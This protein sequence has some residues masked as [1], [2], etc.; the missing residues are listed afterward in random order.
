MADLVLL[1]THEAELRRVLSTPDGSEAAAYLLLG[2][3]AIAS[4]PWAGK[5]RRRLISHRVVPVPEEDRISASGVHVTWSTR[6]FVRLV[7]E[8]ERDGLLLAIVHT[9]PGSGAFFSEQDDR[10]ER[11]LL[12]IVRNRSGD[13]HGFASVVLGGD[14]SICARTWTTPGEA[15]PCSRV[16]V[17]GRRIALHGAAEDDGDEALDRQARLFGPSFNGLVRSMRVGVVGCGG[18][19]SPTVMLLARLG[20]GHLLLIDDDVVETTNLNRIHG[21]RKAD[22]EGRIPKVEVMRREVEAAG[23]GTRVATFKG[24]VGDERVQDAV[25]ACDVIFGCTDDHDGRLFLNRLAYFYGIPVIDMGL[26]M[27]P[28]REGR[29]YEMAGRVTLA[30][31]GVPCLLCRGLIDPRRAAEEALRRIDPAEYEARKAEAYVLDGGDPAPAVVTFT[32][33][34][35]CMAV[36]ELLQGLTGFRGEG[37]MRTGRQRRFDA[38]E[39]RSNTCTPEQGCELCSRADLWGRGDVIPFLHRAG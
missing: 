38:V 11:D 35:A 39:D 17:T 6:S 22:V 5:A 34:T 32:T 30:G 26:R 10:N 33:E 4:D 21:S 16:L 14:G 36:N 24:W 25:R 28:A 12:G 20:V 19:G 27:V 13:G 8:A 15:S 7:K 31:P 2:E 29:P 18:T 23:L 1:D 37:G 9:H 3:A